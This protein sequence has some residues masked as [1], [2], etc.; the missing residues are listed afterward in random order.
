MSAQIDYRVKMAVIKGNTEVAMETI[1][2]ARNLKAEIKMA[3]SR[4]TSSDQ[5]AVDQLKL[6]LNTKNKSTTKYTQT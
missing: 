1:R 5:I 4:F 6:K 2:K 3:E